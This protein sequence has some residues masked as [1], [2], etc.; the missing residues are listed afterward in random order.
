M[1]AGWAYVEAG[2]QKGYVKAVELTSSVSLGNKL[3]NKG[4]TVAK[5][6]KKRVALTFD[7]GPR[8]A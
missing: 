1:I 5:G 2:K 6:Q 7:D 8:W 4:V 3:Y